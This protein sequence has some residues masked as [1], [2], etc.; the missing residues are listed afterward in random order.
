[1]AVPRSSLGG[2]PTLSTEPLIGLNLIT[3]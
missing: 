3:L 2:D 1:M